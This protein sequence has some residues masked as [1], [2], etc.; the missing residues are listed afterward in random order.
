MNRLAV[1]ARGF[2]SDA[3]VMQVEVFASASAFLD[4]RQAFRV[5]IAPIHAGQSTLTLTGLPAGVYA[6]AIAHDENHNGV[7]DTN[8]LGIPKE[9]FGFSNNAMGWVGPP[10]FGKASFRHRGDQ[11]QVT[12][13]VRYR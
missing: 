3:G 12:I 8:W 1:A 11:T 7:I 10:S 2:R 4:H 9:G 13:D 5:G 6:V